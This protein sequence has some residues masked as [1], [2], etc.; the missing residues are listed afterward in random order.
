[1][2]QLTDKVIER[3][4][5]REFDCKEVESNRAMIA[6]AVEIAYAELTVGKERDRRIDKVTTD[7]LSIA[8]RMCGIEIHKALLDKIIDVVEIIEDKG[9]DTSISDVVELMSEWRKS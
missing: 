4:K 9:N 8:L 6:A 5:C 2:K 3:L 1:M 7:N